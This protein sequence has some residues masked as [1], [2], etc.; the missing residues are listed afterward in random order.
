EI[1]LWVQDNGRGIDAEQL[2]HIFDRFWQAKKKERRG[3][4]LGLSICK[5]I[6][7]AHSGRIWAKSAPG[8]GTT[9]FFTVPARPNDQPSGKKKAVANIL[10]V[11]DRPENLVALKA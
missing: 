11:D 4:G 6:V 8:V 5:G 7:E 3:I 1:L 9:M 10:L 2:P